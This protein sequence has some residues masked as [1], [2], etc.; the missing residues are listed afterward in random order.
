MIQSR[1]LLLL[2]IMVSLSACQSEKPYQCTDAIGCVIIP[3]TE[4]LKLGV[5]QTL[6]GGAA[7]G[8]TEQV[9]TIQLAIAQRDNEF[10]G[11]PIELQ[12][13]DDQCSREGGAN[14]AL[15]IIAD[16]QVAAILGTNC[17]S[18][19]IT[20]GSL[21]SQAGLVMISSSNTAPNL[22]ALRGE[23]GINW[24]PGYY[25]TIYNDAY[26][27]QA[28]A[29]F[30]IEE[31]VLK[32]AVTISDGE[33]YTTGLTDM[34]ALEFN[35]LGGNVPSQITIDVEQQDFQPVLVAIANDA[36]DMVYFPLGQPE[37]L[38]RFVKQF[39]E[40]PALENVVLIS[41]EGA[42]SDVFIDK[43]GEAGIGVYMVGPTKINNQASETLHAEYETQYGQ[44]PPSF[45]HNFTYDAVNLLLD[46]MALVTDQ[47]EDGTLYVKRQ[48]LR[49]ALYHT[50]NYEGITG[51]LACNQFG[52]CGVNKLQIV[53][54]DNPS[55]DIDTLESQVIYTYTPK[56]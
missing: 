37:T 28:A 31:L 56:P 4:P 15:K 2:L 39:K 24:Q 8:G 9:R 25:R 45:Y 32:T 23:A 3:P 7:P 18:A 46:T 51:E 55:V 38:S 49:D 40:M 29:K 19:A 17:S 11:H 47:S 50:S 52:D 5:L 43:V 35:D 26:A 22:T 13:E 36:V 16:S 34:F 41:G 12:I 54:L 21:M 6:S 30:A 42:I 27:G 14:A 10:L 53:Q 44:P 33:V 20:A 1:I 48:A